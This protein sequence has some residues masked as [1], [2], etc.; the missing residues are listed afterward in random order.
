VASK[1]CTCDEGFSFFGYEYRCL[2]DLR[3]Q[4]SI[5]V[6]AMGGLENYYIEYYKLYY[7]LYV[8]LSPNTYL[9]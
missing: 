2:W 9:T 4:K 8:A 6:R 3:I 7:S 5:E 1:T